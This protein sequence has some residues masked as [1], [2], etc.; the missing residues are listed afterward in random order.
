MK[1]GTNLLLQDGEYLGDPSHIYIIIDI[2]IILDSSLKNHIWWKPF[3][4]ACVEWI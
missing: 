4:I 1:V 2:D 3:I